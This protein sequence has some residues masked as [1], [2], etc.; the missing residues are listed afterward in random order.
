MKKVMTIALCMAALGSAS[1]Q[2][3]NVDAA[4]KLS[5]KFDKIEE[6]RKLIK[7]AMADPET[8]NDANT[9]FVAGKIEFDAYDKG[10]QQSMI[11]PDDPAAN[12][13]TMG[14]E[15][16]NGYKYFLQALPLDSIPDAKGKSLKHSKDIVSKVAGHANDFFKTAA[17]MYEAK[18][19]YPEAY[20]GFMIFGDMPDMA[21]LGNKAPKIVDA[22]RAQS[23][24]NAGL[25][26]Y[27]G[28]EV[29]KAADA[30]RAARKHGFEDVNGFIYEIA[31]W[32]NIAQRDS[33]ME[34]A[35]SDRIFEIAQDGY[36]KFGAEQPIFLNNLVNSLVNDKKYDEALAKVNALLNNNPQNS[37]LLGLKGF[38]YDRMGDDTASVEC[39][40]KAAALADCDFETLKNIA[41]KL[42]RVGTNE[43]GKLDPKDKDGKLRVRAEYFDAALDTARRAE[44]MAKEKSL[45]D[46]DLQYVI[47]NIE[48]AIQTYY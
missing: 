20:E 32:Q 23:Y 5:G 31:C 12:P 48:Y 38:I 11:K 26:A 13:V 42:Y 45:N 14:Q 24:F 36:A 43:Y 9:Y 47:E 29:L 17:S 33:T 34:K 16:L 30:F 46:S 15:L 25:S 1:A 2:K 41:K 21:W 37:N 44:N 7:E 18:K 39:Y 10:L 8:A 4:K 19:Y 28:N 6:A 3:A 40:R 35:A 22:D 27:S